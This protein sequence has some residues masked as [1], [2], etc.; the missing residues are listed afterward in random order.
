MSSSQ[1][2]SRYPTPQYRRTA[3]LPGIVGA[4]A[5]LAGVAAIGQGIFTLILY[6]VS[7]FAL[8]VLVLA[9]Q[10]RHWWWVPLLAAIAVLFN[11]VF[12]LPLAD[13][14]FAFASYGAAAVFIAAGVLIRVLNK[15]D[16]NRR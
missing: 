6:L 7:I 1:R 15:E 10:A 12:P 2:P 5:A 11:P 4:V 13:L 16:R 14:V 9:V 3:L 8:I